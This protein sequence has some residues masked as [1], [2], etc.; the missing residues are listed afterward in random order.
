MKKFSFLRYTAGI[1]GICLAFSLTSCGDDDK[2][3]PGAPTA[4]GSVGAYFDGSN[5]SSFVLTPEEDSFEIIVSRNDA[6]KACKVP[7]ILV[8]RDTTAIDVP[9]TAYFDAGE[10]I[11]TLTV[12]V[13]NLNLKKVYGFKLAIPESFA[14]HYTMLGGVTTF[15]GKVVVSQWKKVKENIKFYYYGND[16][17]PTTYS[18]MYQLDGVNQ[19][20]ITDFLG[21]GESMQFTIDDSNNDENDP[22]F[23]PDKESTWKGELVPINGQGVASFDY[24]YYKMHYPWHSAED[25]SDVYNWSV[26]DVTINY[27]FWYGGYSYAGDSWIDCSQKYIYLYAW[28]DAFAG[29]WKYSDY[30]TIYGVW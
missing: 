30:A 12:N 16:K 5:N 14:D 29:S 8:S 20:Y 24:S 17:L 9:D 23:D 18:D 25:G 15:S 11:D 13:K 19:F 27:L 4:E 1:L 3:T 26:G 21:T 10:K 28:L 6:T 2:Y 7:I 22:K